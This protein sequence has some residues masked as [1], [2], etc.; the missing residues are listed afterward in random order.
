MDTINFL[1]QFRVGEYAIFDLT[2]SFLGMYLLAPLLSGLFGKIGLEIPK[3]NWLYL[4]LPIGVIT[5]IAIGSMTPMAVNFLNPHDHYILKI[6]IIGLLISGLK[7]IK[8][9][10]I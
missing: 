7:N 2:A 5:H 3:A 1:R 4:T 9:I 8:R 6:V 10:S